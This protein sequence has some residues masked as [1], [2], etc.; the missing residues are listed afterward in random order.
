MA[1]VEISIFGL[2]FVA[3]LG[4]FDMNDELRYKFSIYGY[5]YWGPASRYCELVVSNVT[6]AKSIRNKNH[7][8]I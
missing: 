7:L 3:L 2:G 5:S 6:M 4:G 8:F 1:T